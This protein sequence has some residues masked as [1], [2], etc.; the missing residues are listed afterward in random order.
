[1]VYLAVV[2]GEGV[3]QILELR[4]DLALDDVVVGL[5]DLAEGGPGGVDA[6]ALLNRDLQDLALFVLV[7]VL[8]VVGAEFDLFHQ[9]FFHF[10][11][12]HERLFCGKTG[13][14]APWIRFQAPSI[15]LFAAWTESFAKLTGIIAATEGEGQS[16]SPA[17]SPRLSAGQLRPSPRQDRRVSCHSAAMSSQDGWPASRED[18]T[19]RCTRLRRTNSRPL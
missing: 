9:P 19:Q 3:E 7:D 1:L 11:E 10:I 6:H 18:Y 5:A 16:S 14:R 12:S 17:I 4:D 8:V 2:A 15:G 13:A